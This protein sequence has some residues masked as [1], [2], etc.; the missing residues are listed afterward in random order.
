MTLQ[1]TGVGCGGGTPVAYDRGTTFASYDGSTMTYVSD[2]DLK[3]DG[4]P[5]VAGYLMRKDGIRYRI[6][7]GRVTWME[8]RNG[9]KIRFEFCRDAVH[10]GNMGNPCTSASADADIYSRPVRIVDPLGRTTTIQYASP[11]CERRSHRVFGWAAANDCGSIYAFGEFI[12][13][14]RD[15]DTDRA[16]LVSEHEISGD[17]GTN[18]NGIATIRRWCRPWF[19][20][21]V[22]NSISVITNTA[23]WRG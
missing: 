1:A 8:D 9:N 20:R 23:N 7:G 5:A 21:T 16:G 13:G 2:T 22:R 15:L 10:D 4:S 6:D 12:A 3:D 17:T 11:G 14:Q 18:S 19:C